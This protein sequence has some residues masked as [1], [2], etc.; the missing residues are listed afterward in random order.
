MQADTE[1][2]EANVDEDSVVLQPVLQHALEMDTDHFEDKTQARKR[3][4]LDLFSESLPPLHTS[5]KRARI[6]N[7]AASSDDKTI[8]APSIQTR[9]IVPTFRDGAKII[10]TKLKASDYEDVVQALILH[11]ASQYQ[12]LIATKD[13]FPDT[14]QCVS[15]AQKSWANANWNTDKHYA[16]TERISLLVRCIYIYIIDLFC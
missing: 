10:P 8:A 4:H 2:A 16:I 12:A 3:P 1:D 13:S 9:E 14:V 7:T 11:A 5:T 6:S 15:W